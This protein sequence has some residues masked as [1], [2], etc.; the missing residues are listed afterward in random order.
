MYSNLSTGFSSDIRWAD[1]KIYQNI[2]QTVRLLRITQFQ[3]LTVPICLI[4]V[5]PHATTIGTAA[6][7]NAHHGKRMGKV[8][9]KFVSRFKLEK[10]KVNF[11]VVAPNEHF[12]LF[13]RLNKR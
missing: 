4:A 3:Q 1:A 9:A 5:S 7:P 6:E 11:F 2:R 8:F 12:V 10:E 13:F